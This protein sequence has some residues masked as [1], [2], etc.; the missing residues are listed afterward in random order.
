MRL[1]PVERAAHAHSFPLRHDT[2][3]DI[4]MSTHRHEHDPQSAETIPSARYEGLVSSD[5]GAETLVY[6]LERHAVH[7]LNEVSATVWRQCDGQRTLVEL[8]GACDLKTETVQLALGKLASANLLAGDLPVGMRVPGQSR[9][10]LLKKAAIAGVAVPLVASVT[11]PQAAAN[12][13]QGDCIPHLTDVPGATTANDP[14]CAHCCRP[15][16]GDG[17]CYFQPVPPFGVWRCWGQ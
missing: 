11:A 16:G 9:R 8:A 6:D 7:H 3:E 13:S 10:A 12:H 5:L 2:S 4:A 17:F 15:G 1:V 14:L